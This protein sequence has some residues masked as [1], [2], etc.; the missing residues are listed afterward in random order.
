MDIFK[1]NRNLI[2]TI[3]VLVII[4]IATLSLLWLGKPNPNKIRKPIDGRDEKVRIEKL[5]KKDLGFS[6]QQAEQFLRLQK[7]HRE[8]TNFLAEELQQLKKK[9]FEEAMYSNNFNISDSLLNLS[10]EKQ[11]E[12]ETITFQHFQKVK[13]ICTPEQQE[14]LFK[15]MH[16]LLGPSPRGG[17]PPGARRGRPENDIRPSGDHP[18]RID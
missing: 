2:F 8:K 6:T 12:L 10:L 17:P 13:K 3:I 15:L 11:K 9:M 4:N 7:N 18:S 16:R 14:K 1:K 5:L